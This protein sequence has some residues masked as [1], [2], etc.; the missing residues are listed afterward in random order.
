MNLHP[1]ILPFYGLAW[2][3][4]AGGYDMLRPKYLQPMILRPHILPFYGLV[5]LGILKQL[6]MTMV[7]SAGPATPEQKSV[8]VEAGDNSGTGCS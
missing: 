6:D 3:I 2:D 4:E 8:L 7:F 5:W 1:H